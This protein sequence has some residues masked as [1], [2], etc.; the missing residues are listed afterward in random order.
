MARETKTERLA[1]EAAEL[2]QVLAEQAATY[3]QRL[4][5]MLAR[6]QAANY[7]LQAN[8]DLT[9]TLYDRDDRYVYKYTLNLFFSA[10]AENSLHELTWR[11]ELKEEEVRESKRKYQ[12]KQAALAKLTDEEKELLNL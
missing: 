4:M 11:V 5:T 7:E 10:D 1:R 6:A 12:V 9:F 2:Q 3:P 8:P